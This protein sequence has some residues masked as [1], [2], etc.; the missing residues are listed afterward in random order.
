[1][2]LTRLINPRYNKERPPLQDISILISLVSFMIY[3][4]CLREENGTDDLLRG[5]LYD[6]ID[7]LEL[8]DLLTSLRHNEQEGLDTTALKARLDEII[9]EE[10]KEKSDYDEKEQEL[11]KLYKK[12]IMMKKNKNL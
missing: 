2:K 6:R 1:M 4:F 3:F 5:S 7:G 9:A 8:A 12:A 11:S 10:E